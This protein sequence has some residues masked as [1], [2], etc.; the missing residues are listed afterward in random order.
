M[1]IVHS[2][3]K[4]ERRGI[5]QNSG[6]ELKIIDHPVYASMPTPLRYSTNLSEQVTY[7]RVLPAMTDHTVPT[8][9]LQEST[10]HRRNIN[11]STLCNLRI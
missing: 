7:I 2:D 9:P 1:H 11:Y 8:L 4:E 10:T 5:A 6:T 3:N